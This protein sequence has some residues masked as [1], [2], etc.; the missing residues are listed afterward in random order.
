MY[1][2]VCMHSVIVFIVEMLGRYMSNL[3]FYH[4]KVAKSVMWY[5]KRIKDSMFTYQR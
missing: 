4:W 1:D 5:L 2:K 3:G